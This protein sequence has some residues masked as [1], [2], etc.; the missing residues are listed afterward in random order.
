MPY[1]YI[2][3][4]ND[5]HRE[6]ILS[7]LDEQPLDND[8]KEGIYLSTRLVEK[9]RLEDAKLLE[10][11]DR[12]CKNTPAYRALQKAKERAAEQYDA[13]IDNLKS[14]YRRNRDGECFI[15]KKMEAYQYYGTVLEAFDEVG[16]YKLR[17]NYAANLQKSVK[18]DIL[19]SVTNRRQF[20][21]YKKVA[22]LEAEKEKYLEPYNEKFEAAA[23]RRCKGEVKEA[24]RRADLMDLSNRIEAANRECAVGDM[25]AESYRREIGNVGDKTL[26]S[27]ACDLAKYRSNNFDS[28]IAR[29]ERVHLEEQWEKMEREL[30]DETC[31]DDGSTNKR[32]RN[33]I[34]KTLEFLD[35]LADKRSLRYLPIAENGCKP[36]KVDEFVKSVDASVACISDKIQSG[37]LPISVLEARS[38]DPSSYDVTIE[39]VAPGTKVHNKLENAD[40][41]TDENRCFIVTGTA[42]EQWPINGDKL[43]NKY[44]I[45]P[46]TVEEG[47]QTV[48]HVNGGSDGIWAVPVTGNHKIETSW[49]DVLETN[50]EGV[51]HGDGDFI[52]SNTPDFSDTWVVNGSVF[53][54][55]YEESDDNAFIDKAFGNVATST[56]DKF[57]DDIIASSEQAKKDGGA[58]DMDGMS[59]RDKKADDDRYETFKDKDGNQCRRDRTTGETTIWVEGYDRV[60]RGKVEH[61]K[62][63]WKVL[64]K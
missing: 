1:S 17:R 29:A 31:N 49:G 21:L 23:A 63:Y 62:S 50:A 14:R 34:A 5:Y 39:K 51:E 64:H 30:Y 53:G 36:D 13:R 55:T 7:G 43:K 40:Y 26:N 33:K 61:V 4:G 48:A 24:L 8:T 35:N 11:Y 16:G 19:G 12:D 44:G 38:Y 57:V 10:Q 54:N 56:G 41:V 22:E 15:E 46:D 3:T 32:K 45:D 37:D 42:G 47:E 20:E 59:E 9:Q 18:D 52:V 6:P 25:Y 28:V 2:T 60:R 27:F 58:S